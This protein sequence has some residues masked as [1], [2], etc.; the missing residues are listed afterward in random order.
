MTKKR[1]GP[2]FRGFLQTENAVH[3][4][5]KGRVS[6]PWLNA[7]MP[8]AGSLE[9]FLATYCRTGDVHF[10]Q[11]VFDRVDANGD[12]MVSLDELR[13]LG[14]KLQ[15]AASFARADGVAQVQVSENLKCMHLTVICICGWS[16]CG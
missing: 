2:N 11:D 3:M 14:V 13:Q 16:E 4:P 7:S 5:V 12:G 8:E 6:E 15:P 10:G 1:L 9:A